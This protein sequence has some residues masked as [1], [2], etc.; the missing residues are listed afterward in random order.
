MARIPVIRGFDDMLALKRPRGNSEE[1]TQLHHIDGAALVHGLSK[2]VD[3]PSEQ[4]WARFHERGHR[5]GDDA[6]SHLNAAGLFEGHGEDAAVA[7]TDHLYSDRAALLGLDLTEVTE[8]S[9]RPGR[10]NEQP[11]HFRHGAERD[12]GLDRV[13]QAEVAAE[14]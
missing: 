4:A 10:F 14:V 5:T 2:S 7:E 11:H 12:V 8:R 9:R 1:V 13:E 6:V 3:D